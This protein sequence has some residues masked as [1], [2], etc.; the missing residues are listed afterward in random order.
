ME[1]NFRFENLTFSNLFKEKLVNRYQRNFVFQTFLTHGFDQSSGLGG[2]SSPFTPDI[3]QTPDMDSSSVNGKYQ[4]IVF[5][6][7]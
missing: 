3:L 6:V 7:E 1:G 5:D 4:E 2:V